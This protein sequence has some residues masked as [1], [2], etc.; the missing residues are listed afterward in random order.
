M[1][2]IVHGLIETYG[3]LGLF[4]GAILGNA[5][6]FLPLPVDVLVF[7]IGAA[8]QAAWTPGIIGFVAG[9]GAAIGEMTSYLLG[10]MGISAIEKYQK[11]ELE[12][13]Y[14]VKE[15]LKRKGMLFIFLGAFTPFPFD[16]IGIAAGSR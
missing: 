14:E 2:A 11:K 3:L 15:K 16:V 7:A 9:A 6:V 4:V 13:L 8:A 5:S 10:L 1:E 12:H